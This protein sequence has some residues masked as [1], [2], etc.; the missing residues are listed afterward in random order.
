VASLAAFGQGTI[1]V[2]NINKTGNFT[3]PIFGVNPAAPTVMQ[4]GSPS[5]TVYNGATVF[6][7]PGTTVYGGAP[8]VGAGYDMVFFYSLNTSVTSYSQMTI[9]TTVPFRTAASA[10][11]APAGGIT[12]I[13]ALVIPGGTGGTPI[14][15]EY[16]AFSTEG[17][18][19]TDWAT[20]VANFNA[21]TDKN[22]QIGYGAIAT[23][24][25][26]GSD[27]AGSPHL[28]N[29]SDTGWTSFSLMG[30]PTPEPGT[31][32]LAGLG[33]AGLLLFRRKK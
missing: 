4:T 30:T 1:D 16:A 33:A 12:G 29:T 2:E 17:G 7:A 10:T 11:S 28:G 21:G 18:T 22:A 20:A 14:A 5:P 23:T 24:S 26:N 25:L 19:I 8:L 3:Q 27:T 15:F 31:I 13:G 32:A 9:G 6:P